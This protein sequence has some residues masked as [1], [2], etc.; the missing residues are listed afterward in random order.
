MIIYCTIRSC[1][2]ANF[3]P[4]ATNVVQS[5]VSIPQFDSE[6][7]CRLPESGS[8]SNSRADATEEKMS[9]EPTKR[10]WWQWAAYPSDTTAKAGQE[11][12]QEETGRA[13]DV[14]GQTLRGSIFL[15]RRGDCLFEEKAILAQRLGAAALV[16]RNTEVH[17]L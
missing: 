1:S 17:I 16:V 9:T 3:G 8:S 7:M 6:L 2:I 15:A 10:K 13:K 4:S 12:D 11:H 14:G 5:S